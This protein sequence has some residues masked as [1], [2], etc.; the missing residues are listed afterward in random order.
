ME[1]KKYLKADFLDILFE[2]KNKKYGA[3][4]LRSQ[5]EWRVSKSLISTIC[6]LLVFT[7]TIAF[8]KYIK[9]NDLVERNS[10]KPDLVLQ[11]VNVEKQKLPLPPSP[12]PAPDPPKLKT[13]VKY[14][15]P[16]IVEGELIPPNAEPPDISQLENVAIGTINRKGD[17]RGIN[18]DLLLTSGAGIT[19]AASIPEDSIFIFVEQKP[20]FP[21]GLDALRKY[22][23]DHVRYPTIA[24]EN[25]IQ[26]TVVVQFVVN[27]DGSI[28]G[29]EVMGKKKGGGL[30]DEAIR[31]V[32]SMPKWTPG[33]QNGRNVRVRFNLPIRF[34]LR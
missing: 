21:G 29:V 14:T 23:H 2:G 32:K 24:K 4:L 7:G 22:L 26:G 25:G 30:E 33:K 13:Q 31:V 12:P 28:V 27:T 34:K 1:A 11:S 9:S 8:S 18:S 20:M 19:R 17:S 15:P 3:Y 5:Y 16:K 6:L 10:S